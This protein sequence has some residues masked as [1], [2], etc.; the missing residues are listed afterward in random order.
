LLMVFVLNLLLKW[1]ER[2]SK[3]PGFEIDVK[4]V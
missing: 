3:I 4:R 1:L 2:K